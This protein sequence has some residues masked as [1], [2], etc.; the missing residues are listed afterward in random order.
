VGLG[1]GGGWDA[2]LGT[3]AHARVNEG[4]PASAPVPLLLSEVV[5]VGQ[6]SSLPSEAQCSQGPV[7]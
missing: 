7:R 4:G 1:V 5:L 3:V 2:L 6:A